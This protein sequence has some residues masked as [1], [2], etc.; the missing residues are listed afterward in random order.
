[1][2]SQRGRLIQA[3]PRRQAV[4]LIDEATETGARLFMACKEINVGRQSYY[5]WKSGHV[6]DCRKGAKK[7]VPRKLSEE[8]RKKIVDTCI[9]KEFR[10]LTPYEIYVI[11]LDIEIYTSSIS[12]IYRV[13]RDHDL[14]HHRSLCKRPQTL[15]LST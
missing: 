10:D 6:T 12:T 9:A 2:G 5:R 13:L 1:M 8:E 14:V 11:L 3:E 4:I 7:S 15:I